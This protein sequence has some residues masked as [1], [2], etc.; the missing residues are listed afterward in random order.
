MSM[1]DMLAKLALT[2]ATMAGKAA[3]SY[4]TSFA[5]KRVSAYVASNIGSQ[6]ASPGVTTTP[7]GNSSAVT[8]RKSELEAL[9]HTLERRLAAIG[10]AIDRCEVIAAQ[11]GSEGVNAVLKMSHAV[12]KELEALG[13]VQVATTAHGVDDDAVA[14]MLTNRLK[15]V[16]EKIEDLVPFLQ[17]ALQTSGGVGNTPQ[18][19]SRAQLMRASAAIVKARETSLRGSNSGGRA[20]VGPAFTVRVYTLFMGSARAKVAAAGAASGGKQPMVDWTWKEDFAKASV[21]VQLICHEQHGAAKPDTDDAE[22]ENPFKYELDLVENLNDGRYHE[23]TAASPAPAKDEIVP[24]RTRSLPVSDIRRLFYAVAG[25]LLNIEDVS[26]PVLVLKIV[27]QGAQ[28]EE[29]EGE[30][31]AADSAATPPSAPTEWVALEL[32]RDEEDDDDSSEPEDDDDDHDSDSSAD[33]S[34]T[35]ATP[36]QRHHH[37]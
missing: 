28:A 7:S 8:P 5:V 34:P 2:G 30:A 9:N 32:C 14:A 24:G 3:F 29:G 4:A 10:P 35:P 23:E 21:T 33:K 17:L 37:R 15:S 20:Q 36:A 22:R 25:S 18:G 6:S 31:E 27:R 13:A 19:T 1:E 16:L 12:K 26:S 11:G